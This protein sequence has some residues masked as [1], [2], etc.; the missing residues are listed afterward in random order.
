MQYE[1]KAKNAGAIDALVSM[2]VASQIY[3]DVQNAF[4]LDTAVGVQLDVIGKYAG[5]SRN[6]YDFSGAI[7]LD[8]ADFLT[9]IRVAIIKNT[10][11]SSLYDIE[12][13]LNQFFPGTLLVVDYQTMR[14]SYLFDSSI[15]SLQLAEVMVKQN[16]LPKPM[17]VQLSSVIYG[18]SINDFF[19]FVT[20]TYP[21]AFKSHG[22]N[23]YAV[24]ESDCPWLSY[25][26][27]IQTS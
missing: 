15:G 5:V 14:L 4:D 6:A 12:N 10:F 11:G 22:F 18:P 21:T 17:G 2:V 25:T 7:V 1:G 26:N 24:Y 13:L 19:G 9:M 23:T 3:I 20:Y 27:V 16:L 8:D